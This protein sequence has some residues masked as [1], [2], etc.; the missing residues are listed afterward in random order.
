MMLKARSQRRRGIMRR[1]KQSDQCGDPM[2]VKWD[3]PFTTT[4]AK[5]ELGRKPSSR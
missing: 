5:S 2:G 3:V 4:L 1:E